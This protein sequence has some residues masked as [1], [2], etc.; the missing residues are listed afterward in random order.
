MHGAWWQSQHKGPISESIYPISSV[1]NQECCWRKRSVCMGRR[2][3]MQW[4]D[5]VRNFFFLT[6]FSTTILFIN[7]K[8]SIRLR[9]TLM[10]SVKSA[11]KMNQIDTLG[12][13]SP[14]DPQ[15]VVESFLKR[16]IGDAVVVENTQV[17]SIRHNL[18]RWYVNNRRLMPWR[19]DIVEAID[20]V[21][22]ES[23]SSNDSTC[24]SKLHSESDK[25]KSTTFKRSGY[26]TWISEIMLQ[27]TRVET[28]IPYW[29]KWMAKFPTIQSLASASGLPSVL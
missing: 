22:S 15:E 9:H 24:N 1:W 25:L 18:L 3:R 16:K 17:I 13:S 28:V 7:A 14:A 2:I 23:N 20:T 4:R 8:L 27:Q 6:F 19:G 5:S 12:T 26:G 21:A 10:R 11:A 29:L